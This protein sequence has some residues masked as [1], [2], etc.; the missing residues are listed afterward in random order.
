MNQKLWEE[1]GNK[2]MNNRLQHGNRESLLSTVLSFSLFPHPPP[3]SAL[4]CECPLPGESWLSPMSSHISGHFNPMHSSGKN[5]I[6]RW[7]VASQQKYVL[8]QIRYKG[9]VADQAI[10]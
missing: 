2:K 5:N 9:L 7:A 1:R 8:N 6:K 3:W 10:S 4:V